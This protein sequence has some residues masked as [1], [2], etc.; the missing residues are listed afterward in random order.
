MVRSGRPLGLPGSPPLSK[1]RDLY[2]KLMAQGMSNVAACR[3]VGVNCRT[4][5]RW[6]HW[7]RVVTARG[8]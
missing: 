6:R 3:T 5:K 2:L 4:G 8:K 7:H 1:K